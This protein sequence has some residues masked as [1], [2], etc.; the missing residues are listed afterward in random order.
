MPKQL[1]DQEWDYYQRQDQTAKMAD[2]L[3]NDPATSK[4][5]K[6]LLKQKFPQLQIPDYDIEQ[7]VTQRLDKEKADREAEDKKKK[8]AEEDERIAKSR[9]KTQEEYGFTEEGMADLE[10]FM[11]DNNVGS[12]EVAAGYKASKTPKT[13]EPTFDSTRWHHEKQKGFDEI[14][15]DPEAWGRNELMGAIQRDQEAA[16]QRR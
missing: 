12:Y 16:R 13:S 4:D 10:K 11:V 8:D 5:V 9:K 1:T 2:S 3:Y 15:K 6:R 14:A 7:T